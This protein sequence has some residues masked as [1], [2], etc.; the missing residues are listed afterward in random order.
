MRPTVWRAGIGEMDGMEVRPL[1][2]LQPMGLWSVAYLR[3]ILDK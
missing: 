3:Y 1:K 2:G